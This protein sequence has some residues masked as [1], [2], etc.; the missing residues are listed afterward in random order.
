MNEI[1]VFYSIDLANTIFLVSE[2]NAIVMPVNVP[3]VVPVYLNFGG[4]CGF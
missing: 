4:F 2:D 1:H 3:V